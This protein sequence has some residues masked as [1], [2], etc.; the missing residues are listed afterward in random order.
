MTAVGIVL[1]VQQLFTATKRNFQQQIDAVPLDGIKAL[2]VHT[3]RRTPSESDAIPWEA[4]F[5]HLAA[6]DRQ[7]LINPEGHHRNGVAPAVEFCRSM[8]HVCGWSG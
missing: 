8:M 4:V 5:G 6:V 3:K 2:H 1:D 7:L